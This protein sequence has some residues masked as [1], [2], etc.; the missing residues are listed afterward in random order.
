MSDVVER[1]APRVHFHTWAVV[2]A[3]RDSAYGDQVDMEA[4]ADCPTWRLRVRAARGRKLVEA[5][6]VADAVIEGLNRL[7][8]AGG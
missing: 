2:A 7:G 4:C 8:A 6:A 5:C 1:R 3:S